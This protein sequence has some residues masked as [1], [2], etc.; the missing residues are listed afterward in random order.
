MIHFVYPNASQRRKAFLGC[1]RYCAAEQA[2]AEHY[3][4]AH[5]DKTADLD[6]LL[7]LI[8]KIAPDTRQARTHLYETQDQP[9]EIYG[10]ESKQLAYLFASIATVRSFKLTVTHDIWCTGSIGEAEANGIE[11]GR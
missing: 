5:R 9:Q 11:S 3:T 10:G 6:K 2:P 1:G 7:P 8:R 4:P